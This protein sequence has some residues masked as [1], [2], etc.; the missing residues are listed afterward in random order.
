MASRFLFVAVL[1]LA[2]IQLAHTFMSLRSHTL[3]PVQ[4]HWQ[5]VFMSKDG[6]YS[7]SDLRKLGKQLSAVDIASP[8]MNSRRITA[9]IQIDTP[10]DTVWSILTDYNN[11]TTHVPNLVKSYLVP[12]PAGKR[13]LFQ[14]GAQKIVGFDFRASLTMEM[15]EQRD[16]ISYNPSREWSIRFR[17]IESRMFDSFDGI[18]QLTSLSPER[19]KLLYSVYVRPRG[20]V[21]VMALEWRIKED[22]P[23]N[24]YAVKLASEKR[25]AYSKPART[26]VVVS[27]TRGVSTGGLG[28]GLRGNN[29]PTRSPTSIAS[30]RESTIIANTKPLNPPWDTEETLGTYIF[31]PRNSTT[32]SA[33]A[34]G[35]YNPTPGNPSAEKE[36]AG[37][38]RSRWLD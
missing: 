23:L 32:A 22:V 17:L 10:R 19:T 24:L 13:R 31:A 8:S 28:G 15:D 25:Y 38:S 27:N 34:S 37:R 4:L 1:W 16:D 7:P 30:V 29:M 12:H 21:P 2:C 5:G 9:H 3:F 35:V 26:N 33:S 11:L 6:S 20:V 14:E 36:R 18:W